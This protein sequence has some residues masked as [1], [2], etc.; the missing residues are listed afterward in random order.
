[1][2]GLGF[3]AHFIGLYLPAEWAGP[4][5]SDDTLGIEEHF[6]NNLLELYRAAA[7]RTGG[8]QFCVTST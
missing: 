2:V 3:D 6:G 4:G 8:I 1:M 5:S 7:S